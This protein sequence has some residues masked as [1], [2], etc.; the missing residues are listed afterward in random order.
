MAVKRVEEHL[1]AHWWGLTLRGIAAI[2]F[3]VAAVFWPGLTLVT[4]IYLLSAFVLVSGVINVAQAFMAIGRRATWVLTLLLGLAEVGV[5]V[6][7]VRHPAVSFAT[8]V[9]V[10]GFLFVARGV[11]EVVVALS[12]PASATARTLTLIAGVA[13]FVLGIFLLFQPESAGIAFVWVLGLYALISGPLLIAMS[14]D[15]KAALEQ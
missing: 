9:L 13:S 15:V 12:E 10:A 11:F 2:F 3:G 7:L 14:L 5:G 6:Y 8:F 4:L 1:A